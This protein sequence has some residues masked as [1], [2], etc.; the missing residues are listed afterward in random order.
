MRP[1]FCQGTQFTLG[2][3]SVCRRVERGEEKEDMEGKAISSVKVPYTMLIAEAN[4]FIIGI[5][6]SK[7]S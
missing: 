2:K 5:S 3:G 7:D 1:F 6:V 4:V